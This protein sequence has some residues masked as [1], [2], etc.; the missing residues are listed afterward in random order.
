MKRFEEPKGTAIV[1]TAIVLSI[2]AVFIADLLT[3]RGIAVWVFYLVPVALTLF[4]WRPRAPL[5]VAA[6]ATVAIAIS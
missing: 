6:L 5:Y 3:P 2:A 4:E 1:R